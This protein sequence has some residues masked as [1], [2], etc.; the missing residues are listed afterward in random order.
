[1][2]LIGDM[3][4]RTPATRPVPRRTDGHILCKGK[5]SKEGACN[6]REMKGSASHNACLRHPMQG[7]RQLQM[8]SC[9]PVNAG[10][11]Q[12]VQASL[13]SSKVVVHASTC[14]PHP[15]CRRTA[16]QTLLRSRGCAAP[17]A[18][19]CCRLHRVGA[20]SQS[21]HLANAACGCEELA[22]LHANIPTLVVAAA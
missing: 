3:R 17:R 10:C 21:V 14:R 1:M 13:R 16:A 18:P 6:I 5:Q 11:R 19:A 15:H 20:E 22:Q 9:A 8:A 12:P 4:C 7:N 2:L